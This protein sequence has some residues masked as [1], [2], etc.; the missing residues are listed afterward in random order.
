ANAWSKNLAFHPSTPHLLRNVDIKKAEGR[1]SSLR[2]LEI[3]KVSASIL[4]REEFKDKPLRLSMLEA[5]IPENNQT[6]TKSQ[7]KDILH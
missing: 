4:L 2:F 3:A 1:I 5:V 6:L 7:A